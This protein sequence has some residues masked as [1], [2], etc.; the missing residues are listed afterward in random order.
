M[1]GGRNGG[2]GNAAGGGRSNA[3]GSGPGNGRNNAAGRLLRRGLRSGLPPGRPW[4]AGAPSGWTGRVRFLLG[5]PGLAL[6]LLLLALVLLAAV[7]PGLF[8]GRDPLT[9]VPADKLLAPSVHHP[10]G[11]DQ[12]GRDLFARTVHGSSASLRA[13]GLAVGIALFAGSA[14]GL[15]AGALRGWVDV[16]LTRCTDVLLSIP[17]LLLSLAVVTAL[18]FGTVKVA[19]AVGLTSVAGFA[20]LMRAEVL[21][22]RAADYVE[23]AHS[24]GVRRHAVVLRHVLPNAWGPVLVFA[25]VEFGTVLLAVSALSFLGYGAEPPQPEWGAL[26]ADGRDYL[27]TAWWLTTLPGLTIAATVLAA[28]RIARALEREEEASVR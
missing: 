23:A 3:V 9:G 28:N 12:L 5:R 17:A 20:R 16:V 27:A 2:L 4:R 18:G 10:F 26:V 11:T 8:T 13:A 21:R 22:V 19:L 15:L 24:L 1:S 7:A 6:S 14:V 25:A